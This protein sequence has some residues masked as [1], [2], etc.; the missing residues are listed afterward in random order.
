MS[1]GLPAALIA[2][3][4]ARADIMK[5]GTPPVN[6]D[7][8][9]SEM[10]VLRRTDWTSTLPRTWLLRPAVT[11]DRITVHHVG[12]TKN[13]DLAKHSVIRD[14]DGILT[15]HMDRNYGDVGYHF[16]I[17]YAGRLWETRSL[18]YEG[19]H[20]SGQNDRN[21]GI[22]CAGNFDLQKPSEEQLITLEQIVTVLREHYGI[23]QNQL[24]GHRDIGHSACPG[25]SLYPHVVK[26]RS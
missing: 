10:D 18:A 7:F 8:I 2:S 9:S 24:F 17:D 12:K 20:V 19:A 4:S 21:I 11:F 25:D 13:V 3:K 22:V 26:L 15:E 16:A 14:L 1:V 5:R 23:K 6:L